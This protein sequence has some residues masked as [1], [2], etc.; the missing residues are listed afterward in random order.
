MK[1]LVLTE[2]ALLCVRKMEL[3]AVFAISGFVI[4][5]LLIVDTNDNLDKKLS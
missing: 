1:G 2:V 4:D 3:F 5:T